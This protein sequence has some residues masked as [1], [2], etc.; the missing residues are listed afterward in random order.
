MTLPVQAL[1][2]KEL[3]LRGSFRFHEEFFAGVDLMRA[4]LID[5]APLITHTLPLA[6]AV[7]AFE[8]AGDRGQA[9]KA[10]IDFA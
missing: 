10:Q 8:I 3:D 1:T 5:V 2:A 7:D 4:G 9:V 6:E